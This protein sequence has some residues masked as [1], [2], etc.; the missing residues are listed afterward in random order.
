MMG[1]TDSYLV[2]VPMTSLKDEDKPQS[3]RTSPSPQMC[4]RRNLCGAPEGKN[5]M[6]KLSEENVASPKVSPTH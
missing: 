5:R 4:L 1:V 2:L 6:N 3:L